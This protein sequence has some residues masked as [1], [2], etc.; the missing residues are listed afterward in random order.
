MGS[1]WPLEDGR[2]RTELVR[3]PPS[4][5]LCQ[6]RPGPRFHLCLRVQNKLLSGPSAPGPAW[7]PEALPAP[8]R[9]AVAGTRLASPLHRCLSSGP[10]PTHTSSPVPPLCSGFGHAPADGVRSHLSCAPSVTASM[11]PHPSPRPRPLT[12]PLCSGPC[13]PPA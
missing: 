6:L 1:V 12:P 11:T 3:F 5:W 8:D 13:Q 2:V 10:V 9:R 4:G 7:L